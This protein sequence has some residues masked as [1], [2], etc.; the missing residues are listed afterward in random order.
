MTETAL[1]PRW[2]PLRFHPEQH[3]LRTLPHRFKVVPAGRRSGKTELAKRFIVQRALMPTAFPDPHFFAAAPTWM[4]AKRIFW[5]DIKKLI[6]RKFMIGRP[7]ES[8]LMI[9]LVT[10]AE[11]YVVGLDKPE[12]IEG[13]PDRKSVV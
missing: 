5:P 13:Q 2:Q 6:P 3:R 11:I 1:T 7:S 8:E 4:Q 9:R 12:R 10:G